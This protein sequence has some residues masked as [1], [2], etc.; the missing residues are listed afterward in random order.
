MKCDQ[1]EVVY[2][3]QLFQ[4]LHHPVE[5]R[6]KPYES[7]RRIGST[8]VLPILNDGHDGSSVLMVENDRAHEGVFTELPGGN[9]AYFDEVEDTEDP[10]SPDPLAVGLREL[11]EET[12]YAPGDQSQKPEL[13]KL[14]NSS[15]AIGYDRHLLIARGL[16]HVGGEL[17]SPREK[18][19]LRP[20][21]IRDYLD[22][23]FEL[24]R[25]ELQSEVAIALARAS[26]HCGRDAVLGWLETGEGVTDIQRS[27]APDLIAV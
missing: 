23:I 26:M 16:V 13:Y 9:D 2:S 6:A 18:I 7:V 19:T 5:G 20:V 12:G 11:R 14:K 15:R 17:M 3:G 4:V 21:P 22:P 10:V 1:T 27:F 24:A 8:T 25:H